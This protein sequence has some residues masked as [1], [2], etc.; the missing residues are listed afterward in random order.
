MAMDEND[1]IRLNLDEES[2]SGSV[3]RGERIT[4]ERYVVFLDI[5]GF[6]DRVARTSHD[7]LRQLLSEFNKDMTGLIGKYAEKSNI[8]LAQFSDSIVLFSDD[9]EPDSLHTVIK[10]ACGIMLK[11][12]EKG[13]PLKGAIA[14]GEITCDMTKQL[15]FGQALID[16]YLLEE[17]IQYYGI[18]V[19]HSVEEAVEEQKEQGSFFKN[20]KAPLKS[21]FISH[22]EL[23]WYQ[24]VEKDKS[25]IKNDLKRIR[26]TVSDAPRKYIDNTLNVIDQNNC[27]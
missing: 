16:A 15:F 19:H 8:Q 4:A 17:N 1:K 5:M 12:I 13:I 21:G 6:K 7:T 11:A 9:I 14:R 23:A 24:T 25:A 22:Y 2:S 3:F 26:Q 18:L 27:N 20:V 10:V